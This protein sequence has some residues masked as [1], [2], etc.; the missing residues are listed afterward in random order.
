MLMAVMLMLLLL[1]MLHDDLPVLSLSL[2]GAS[3]LLCPGVSLS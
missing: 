3:Q 2:S 1:L